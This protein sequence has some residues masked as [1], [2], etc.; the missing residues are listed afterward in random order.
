MQKL[1]DKIDEN[2]STWIMGKSATTEVNG[3]GIA[4]V[5]ISIAQLVEFLL[6]DKSSHKGVL[7]VKYDRLEERRLIS[8]LGPASCFV[9]LNNLVTTARVSPFH[10]IVAADLVFVPF[11]G[12]KFPRTQSLETLV[13]WARDERLSY[14]RHHDNDHIYFYAFPDPVEKKIFQFFLSLAIFRESFS[15]LRI[16]QDAW[17]PIRK[18]MYLHGWTLNRRDCSY[19]AGVFQYV[20]WGGI[21]RVS[22]LT[23]QESARLSLVKQKLTLNV[24]EFRDDIEVSIAPETCSLEDQY[25]TYCSPKIA[26]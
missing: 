14:V 18:G 17:V 10:G 25:G 2:W 15:K 24:R 13:Q 11:A 22:L 20:L 5:Y 6:E 12:S 23:S 9:D 1:T 16:S 21:P 26:T 4:F 3:K 7:L 19:R 8:R